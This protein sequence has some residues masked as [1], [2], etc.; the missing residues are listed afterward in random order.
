MNRRRHYD[1]VLLGFF[2]LAL[3]L[4]LLVLRLTPQGMLFTTPAKP[5]RVYVEVRPPEARGRELDL[6]APEEETPRDR[7]ARRLGPADRQVEKET[8]PRGEAPEDRAPPSVPTPP[9]PPAA[10]RPPRTAI[11]RMAPEGTGPAS[12]AEAPSAEP[13]PEVRP[14]PRELPDLETLAQ[15]APS[16][17]ARLEQDRRRKYREEVEEGDAV[18]LDTER[19]I[20][21]SFFQ[22]LRDNIYLVWGYPERSKARREEGTCLLE[23][24]VNRDGS[25]NQVR[26]LE[27]SGYPLLDEAALE[28]VRKGAPFGRLP[29]AYQKESIRILANFRYTL[30]QRLIY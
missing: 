9:R 6:P 23:I 11:E 30:V 14:A 27:S 2:I 29:R 21:L 18:W 12:G 26:L 3:A 15:L 19:D 28:A 25:L 16:T 1:P 24:V 13:A 8:A 10:V 5:E 7:P 22:R 4:H 20:L 17:I